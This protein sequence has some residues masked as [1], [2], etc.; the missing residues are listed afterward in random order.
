MFSTS[1][2]LGSFAILA[3]GGIAVGVAVGF[4]V[5]NLLVYLDD[6]YL[7][8]TA[9]CLCA[10][11]SYIAGEML[12]VSGVIATVSCG[13]MLGW[14]QHDV[15]S[16]AVRMRGTAFWQ[17]VVFLMEALV[18]ILIGLSLR[19]VIVR[20][21][22]VRDALAAF[23]PTVT[24]ILA[25]VV[26]ARFVWVFGT[27]ALKRPLCKLLRRDDTAPDW[28]SAAV[29]SWAGMRGVVTLAIALSLPDT[30]PGRDLILVAAF[31]VIL[32]TVLGQ[33][34]TIGPLI[35]WVKP[36]HVARDERL[37]SEPQAWARLEA[38]QLAAIQPLVHDAEGNVI[39]P[40]LLEQ[41]SYRARITETYQFETAF[42]TDERTAHYDVVLAAV[43]A[44]RV[45]L[46]RMHRSELIDDEMLT[47]LEHDLDLQEIAARHG[48]G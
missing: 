24:A 4:L 25:A 5:V 13:M 2:A 34:T 14:Y 31:A 41:Y 3:L 45:E 15:F 19:G 37:L 36:A 1:H 6:D 40:R 48:R 18:F 42:P 39:H 28:R 27:E 7:I 46:L 23:T 47:V 29:T 9:S 38:A 16:A 21:G 10:W 12:D 35:R 44:G 33:G 8:I 43:A 26:L 11:I 17:V 22:G 30:M 20:L 32:V